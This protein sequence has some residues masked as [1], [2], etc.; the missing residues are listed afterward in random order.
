M[1]KYDAVMRFN[2]AAKQNQSEH[3]AP[4]DLLHNPPPPIRHLCCLLLGK[5]E[6][7]VRQPRRASFTLD[8]F[9]FVTFVSEN[10][11]ESLKNEAL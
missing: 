6:R 11:N 8:A 5:D 4:F 7:R 1:L 3:L 2:R 9:V 10:L